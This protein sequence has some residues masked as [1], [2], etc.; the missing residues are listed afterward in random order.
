M[1]NGNETALRQC[2][3]LNDGYDEELYAAFIEA[4]SDYVIPFALTK[5]QFRN[6]LNSTAVDVRRSVGCIEE[7]RIVGFSL[8]GIGLWDGIPSVYDAGTGVV[9]RCRRQG[10]SEAMFEMMLPV[11]REE[12]ER[13]FLLEVVTTN[14]SAIALYEKFDFR[15]V[16]DLG[17]LQ[18]DGVPNLSTETLPNLQ[19][20][21]IDVLNWELLTTFWDGRPSWQNSVDAVMRT[22]QKKRILGAFLEGLCVGYI[23]FSSKFGR[24]AQIAVD[25]EHRNRG[26][27]S[28]LLRATQAETAA[29]FSLQVINIDKSLTSAM[30]FFN[31]RG[32]YERLVQFEMVLQI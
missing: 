24:I 6:H 32:F 9:P 14:A 29:G 27:G 4:F 22:R 20:H 11:F 21:S 26:I 30:T 10:V 5:T 25:K 28:A 18:C 15:P 8:N 13:Q 2:R 16:R 19:L 31:S 12:G 7:G 23:V 17:L 3:F 1:D